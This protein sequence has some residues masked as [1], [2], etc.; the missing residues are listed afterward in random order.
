MLSFE[1][2]EQLF[3]E[4]KAIYNNKISINTINS[5]TKLN[6]FNTTST[7]VVTPVIKPEDANPTRKLKSANGMIKKSTFSLVKNTS[8][9]SSY[10]SSEIREKEKLNSL[11]VPMSTK[12][13]NSNSNP[14]GSSKEMSSKQTPT[15]VKH[16]QY[17]VDQVISNMP[18]TSKNAKSKVINF[19]VNQNNNI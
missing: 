15:V 10:V 17:E 6:S 19:G 8:L 5:N 13:S 14:F 7:K 4:H 3:S 9:T 1:G 11:I 18:S 16:R 2:F 12:N